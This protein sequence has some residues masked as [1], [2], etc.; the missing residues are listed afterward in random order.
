MSIK[1]QFKELK[2]LLKV[3]VKLLFFLPLPVSFYRKIIT[4]KGSAARLVSRLINP[5]ELL[6]VIPLYHGHFFVLF[7][8]L[9]YTKMGNPV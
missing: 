9:F 4:H 6:P 7:L 3:K 8:C 5:L 1:N 2:M